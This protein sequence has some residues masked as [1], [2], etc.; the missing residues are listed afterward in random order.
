MSTKSD[1]PPPPDLSSL[2]KRR[3]ELTEQEIKL[4]KWEEFALSVEEHFH[5][6]E[7]WQ[8]NPNGVPMGHR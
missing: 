8:R 6:L 5:A 2:N 1:L 3:V 4:V 7:L